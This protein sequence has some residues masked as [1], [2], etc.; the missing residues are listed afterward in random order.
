MEKTYLISGAGSGIGRATAIALAESHSKLVLLGRNRA[1]LEET[2]S[3][4]RDPERHCVAVADLRI[5]GEL[6]SALESAL[7]KEQG[8]GGVIANAGVGGENH[9]GA[10][11]RWDEIVATNLTGTYHLV[12][13]ALPYLE[14]SP[15]RYRH[16]VVVSS[17]LARLG[18]PG[19]S[20]YC[21]SKAGLLGLVRSWAAEWASKQ[22]LVNAICPGWVETEMAVEGLEAFSRATGKSL[23]EVRAA[24]MSRVPLGKMSHPAEIGAL[25][26]YLVSEGQTSITGQAIDINNG[27]I[28]P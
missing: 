25:V 8:L 23:D 11:D 6:A 26:R 10:E 15:A 7:A 16:V 22:V 3:L 27:A 14:R 24:E 5:P 13:L 28:M 17:I 9:Y 21:A 12:N 18:V 2:R 4:L 1:K 20:A 19:Y